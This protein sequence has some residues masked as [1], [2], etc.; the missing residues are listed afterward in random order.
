MCRCDGG[1]YGAF[2]SRDGTVVI[3][4]NW[5]DALAQLALYLQTRA[6]QSIPESFPSTLSRVHQRHTNSS[7]RNSSTVRRRYKRQ[8]PH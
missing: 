4:K 3:Y 8:K 2:T 7:Q 1:A 5:A 6:R